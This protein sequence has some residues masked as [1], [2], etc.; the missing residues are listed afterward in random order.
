[1]AYILWFKHFLIF[2]KWCFLSK[3]I[4]FRKYTGCKSEHFCFSK[5]LLRPWD[6]S[7]SIDLEIWMSIAGWKLLYDPK[8]AFPSGVQV[9]NRISAPMLYLTLGNQM[10]MFFNLYDTSTK[11]CT[12]TWPTCGGYQYKRKRSNVLTPSALKR[13][14]RRIP[15]QLRPVWRTHHHTILSQKVEVS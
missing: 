6:L 15:L 3:I 4:I 14:H 12:V 5:L 7:R 2:A 8:T 10:F 9:D 1:M 13:N 11:V